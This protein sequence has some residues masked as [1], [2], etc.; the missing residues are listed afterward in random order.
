MK[1]S[2]RRTALAVVAASVLSAVSLAAA[3]PAGEVV[4]SHVTATRSSC[5][6]HHGIPVLA[7][8]PTRSC[9]AEGEVG[10]HATTVTPVTRKGRFGHPTRVPNANGAFG[11]ACPRPRFCLA[12][13]QAD[14]PATSALVIP[15]R[16]GRPTAPQFVADSYLAWISCGSRSSCWALGGNPRRRVGHLV[17][18]VSGRIV[19]QY[20]M[21]GILGGGLTCVSA[22]R[23]L[24]PAVTSKGASKVMT[25]DRGRVTRASRWTARPPYGPDHTACQT[26]TECVVISTGSNPSTGLLLGAVLAT[27]TDGRVG[28]ARHIPGVSALFDVTCSPTACFAFGAGGGHGFVVP[29]VDGTVGDPIRV[30]LD[31]DAQVCGLRNCFGFMVGR[32][33]NFTYSVSA[34]A[35][36]G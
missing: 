14:S 13:A 11:L 22:S 1:R 33:V 2:Q 27:I 25:L 5:L 30:R 10:D 6:A 19:R 23:C 3:A 20:T 36:S 34:P 7:C 16:A 18:I 17:H 28:P 32:F 15:I 9:I 29:I 26:P 21:R 8:P 12:L 24:M 4:I 35:G 31:L